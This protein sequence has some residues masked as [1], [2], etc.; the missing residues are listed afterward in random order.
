[1]SNGKTSHLILTRRVAFPALGN[2]PGQIAAVL[3]S[4]DDNAFTFTATPIAQAAP[5]VAGLPYRLGLK[6]VSNRPAGGGDPT[7]GLLTVTLQ[8]VNAGATGT[9]SVPVSDVPVDYVSDPSAP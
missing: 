7:D 4:D 3:V 9:D 2:A 1:L 8:V 5:A 6:L